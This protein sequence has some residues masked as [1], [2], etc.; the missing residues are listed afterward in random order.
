MVYPS[1]YLCYTSE[2]GLDMYKST[3]D[4]TGNHNKGDIVMKNKKC[5]IIFLLMITAATLAIL[6]Y[7]K[8]DIIEIAVIDTGINLDD[9]SKEYQIKKYNIT[10]EGD[11]THGT[12]VSSIILGNI[13]AS[14]SVKVHI[15]DV[16]EYDK[17]DIDNLI[18]GIEKA[19]DL[20]VDIINI[21]LGTY[22]DDSELKRVIDSAI[23]KGII[24]IC[25][26][27]DDYTQQYLYPAS[28][29]GVYSVS[30]IDS[31]NE[32][33][34]N[35]NRNDMILVCE[36]GENVETL[37]T[38]DNKVK[39][40]IGSSASAALFTSKIVRLKIDYPD[41]NN[42]MLMNVIKNA[43]IDFGLDGKDDIFGYGLLDIEKAKSYLK[44]VCD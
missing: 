16:G 25:S 37:I 38:E 1:G 9:W 22:K 23:E 8:R 27:G 44:S 5:I 15:I 36:L 11:N 21:S 13:H 39:M 14:N 35:N 41:L 29:P 2:K 33:L 43:T 34:I 17:L 19:K 40:I 6:T 10:K 28:Y 3:I 31:N 4:E 12:Y 20:N 32:P 42:E 24:I 30:C 7:K 18:K 26:S